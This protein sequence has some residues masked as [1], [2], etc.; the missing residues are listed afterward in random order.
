[1]RSLRA[2]NLRHRRHD[3]S[4]HTQ[5]AAAVVPGD[6]DHHHAEEWGQRPGSTARSGTGQLPNRLDLDAQAEASDGAPGAGAID[7][8]RRGR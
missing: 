8:P 7:G 4:R 5:A 2:A 3:L 6:V 1:M